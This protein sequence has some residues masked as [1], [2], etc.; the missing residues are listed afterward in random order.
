MKKLVFFFLFFV[1]GYY[2]IYAQSWQIGISAKPLLSYPAFGELDYA[3][4]SMRYLPLPSYALGLSFREAITPKWNLETGISLAR[5]GYRLSYTRIYALGQ[6]ITHNF[7]SRPS[8]FLFEIPIGV[9]YKI[10]KPDKKW[11]FSIHAG[12]NVLVSR[13]ARGIAVAYS[14]FKKDIRSTN[15]PDMTIIRETE[16][17]PFVKVNPYLKVS[18]ERNVGGNQYL[19]IGLIH[20]QGLST[21]YKSKVSYTEDKENFENHIYVRGSYTGLQFTYFFSLRNKVS[22]PQY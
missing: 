16:I 12:A 18:V 13:Q 19:S 10:S 8:W 4:H 11:I 14:V 20:Q 1:L 15:P 3:H 22:L 9:Q 17:S 21:I 6:R 7:V 5:L 2:A